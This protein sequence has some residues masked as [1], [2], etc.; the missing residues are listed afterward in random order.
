MKKR[1]RQQ[2]SEGTIGRAGVPEGSADMKR[3]A[4]PPIS[5]AVASFRTHNFV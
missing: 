5:M 1:R 2:Q 4:W 3:N